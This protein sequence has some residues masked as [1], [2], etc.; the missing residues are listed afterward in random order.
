VRPTTKSFLW[1]AVAGI[2]ATW[3]LHAVMPGARAVGQ[4]GG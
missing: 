1:G 4:P 3:V 2:V